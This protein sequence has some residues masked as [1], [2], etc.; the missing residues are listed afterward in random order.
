MNNNQRPGA[1][2]PGAFA[3]LLTLTAAVIGA[4]ILGGI[5]Q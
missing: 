2:I 4:A 1:F 3:I 5:P